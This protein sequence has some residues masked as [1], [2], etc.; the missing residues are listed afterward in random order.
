MTTNMN[1]ERMLPD[2]SPKIALPPAV[3]VGPVRT[4]PYTDPIPL[5]DYKTNQPTKEEYLDLGSGG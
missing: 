4:A 5:K 2:N 1:V 3:D